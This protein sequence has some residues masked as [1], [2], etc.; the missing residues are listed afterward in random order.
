MKRGWRFTYYYDV[1]LLLR[2]RHCFCV[3]RQVLKHGQGGL[4][5]VVVQMWLRTVGKQLSATIN[6]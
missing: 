4:L 2:R 1:L 3:R 5:G 6:P